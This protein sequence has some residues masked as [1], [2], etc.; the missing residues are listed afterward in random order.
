MQVNNYG[1]VNGQNNTQNTY[2]APTQ[3]IFVRLRES[4]ETLEQLI[5]DGSVPPEAGMQAVRELRAS[6]EESP[7]QPTGRLRAAAERVRTLLSAGGAAADDV[8]R[9]AQA[10]AAIGAAI[11]SFG[12]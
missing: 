7:A 10:I 3:N 4:L 11:G 1:T 9:A 6:M 5:A 12:G 2:N 8:G